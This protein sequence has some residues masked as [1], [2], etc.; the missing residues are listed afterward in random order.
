MNGNTRALRSKTSKTVNTSKKKSTFISEEKSG[1]NNSYITIVSE[2]DIDETNKDTQSN[3]IISLR[4]RLA[5]LHNQYESRDVDC[6]KLLKELESMRIKLEHKDILIAKLEKIIDTLSHQETL[7][8]RDCATQTKDVMMPEAVPEPVPVSESTH[9]QPPGADD[10]SSATDDLGD[11]SLKRKSRVLVLGDSGCRGSGEIL[12]DSLGNDYSV[13]TFCKPYAEMSDILANID[14]MCRHFHERDFVII[15][16]GINDLIKRN[17]IPDLILTKL[18]SLTTKCHVICLSVAYWTGKDSL[19]NKIFSFNN[20]LYHVFQS[21]G[22]S[23]SHFVDVNHFLSDDR[24]VGRKSRLTL[25]NKRRLFVY[26]S[27]TIKNVHS[28]SDYC[29]RTV[30]TVQCVTDIQVTNDQSVDVTHTAPVAP[31]FLLID[32]LIA[33]T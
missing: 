12:C 19:N 3:V 18:Q 29:G 21:L 32:S 22:N 33:G 16:G 7:T 14:V 25:S 6:A 13:L 27:D 9:L 11:T 8:V 1:A 28:G 31:N 15:S 23:R 5:D 20:K 4:N 17:L 26:I 10:G 30:V 2:N 24:D